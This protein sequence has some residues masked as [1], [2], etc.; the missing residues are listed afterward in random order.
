MYCVI[1]S[2]HVVIRNSTNRSACIWYHRYSCLAFESFMVYV[3]VANTMFIVNN[4]RV[5][6]RC[7]D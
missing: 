6:H 1:K 5:V 7:H 2:I 4:I 3:G